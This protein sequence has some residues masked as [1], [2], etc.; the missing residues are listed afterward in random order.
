MPIDP[1]IK[2]LQMQL[3]SSADPL[4]ATRLECI[5][6]KNR[7]KTI[8]LPKLSREE[9]EALK[10]NLAEFQ[11]RKSDELQYKI[12]NL[13]NAFLIIDELEEN[14]NLR[15]KIYPILKYLWEFKKVF[16][17][18]I[19][20]MDK[21]P[22]QKLELILKMLNFEIELFYIKYNRLLIDTDMTNLAF[23]ER[24]EFTHDEIDETDSSEEP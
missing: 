11:K 17:T 16:D 9:V 5:E 15:R 19:E 21:K 8:E 6:I 12:L 18:I 22:T 24:R 20:N 2:K 14:Q 7:I 4:L 1:M 10:K 23:T 3:M 13:R